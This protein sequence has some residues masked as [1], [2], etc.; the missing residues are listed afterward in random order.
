[1][2]YNNA[3]QIKRDILFRTFKALL[4]KDFTGLDRI[5]V[6][7]APRD[8]N[9]IRCC[10]HKDRAV[11]K[12]RVMAALGFSIEDETDEIKQLS[13]YGKES[14][15]NKELDDR[16]LTVIHDAC[17]SCQLGHHYISDVCVGCMAR[18]CNTVCPKGAINVV[19]GRSVINKSLC[20]DCGKCTDV[21]P[22]NAVIKVSVP[23]ESNCPVSALKKREDGVAQIDKSQCISCGKCIKSCPFGAIVEKS[24]ISK[25]ISLL[26]SGE[27]VNALIAP[28]IVGQFPG[29]LFQIKSALKKIGYNRVIEVGN[30]AGEVAEMEAKEFLDHDEDLLTSSCCPSYMLCVNRHGEGVAKYISNTKTPMSLAGDK[31]KKSEPNSINVFIGP[32]NAKKVEAFND[33]NID[34]VL[35]YEELG[36]HL[37]AVDL[38]IASLK[39]GNL[40][41]NKSGYGFAK[42][43]GVLDGVSLALRDHGVWITGESVDGIDR[44]FV[45]KLKAFDKISKHYDF[46]EVMACEGGCLNGPGVIVSKSVSEKALDSLKKL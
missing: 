23:C 33:D 31:A 27:K 38:D 11:L 15:D 25:V 37:M 7:S 41:V 21:C 39:D 12:Y 30:L 1:M 34:Y 24:Q 10:I 26:L 14:L 6:E 42:S 5:P 45:K 40:S 32:C 2:L 9:N 3:V 16:V 43:G 46:L 35:T 29:S 22:Y 13:L 20:I 44:K 28:S 8:K 18:P 17:S 36:A 4:N 19:N